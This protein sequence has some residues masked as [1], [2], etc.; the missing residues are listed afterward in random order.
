MRDALKRGVRRREMQK[1]EMQ[2]RELNLSEPQMKEAQNYFALVNSVLQTSIDRK[3]AIAALKLAEAAAFLETK[4]SETVVIK[5]ADFSNLEGLIEGIE[6]IRQNQ[7]PHQE[8]YQESY[9]EPSDLFRSAL[10]SLN[11]KDQFIGYSD[12]QISPAQNLELF[13]ISDFSQA[14][15]NLP[16]E[17]RETAQYMVV[18]VYEK[19][20]SMI[21]SRRY[22]THDKLDEKFKEIINELCSSEGKYLNEANHN[23]LKKILDKF[24]DE[25]I[26]D[27]AE[28]SE[29]NIE[30]EADSGLSIGQQ[31]EM[32]KDMK[33][34]E[35][36][37]ETES[38]LKF[39]SM[40]LN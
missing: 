7:E 31:R 15:F 28:M 11:N 30:D 32:E 10:E 29:M 13:L 22:N 1:A 34:Y 4:L 39:L 16:R 40:L 8:S 17:K 37:C 25:E 3:H 9:Q 24:F 33:A 38:V 2:K 23:L 6:K 35:K 27:H 12:F 21:F 36:A 18:G 20:R 26:S 19:I 14:Y 5:G